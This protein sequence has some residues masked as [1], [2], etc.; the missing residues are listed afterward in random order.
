[1]GRNLK[2]MAVIETGQKSE[3]GR[4]KLCGCGQDLTGFQNLSGLGI[5]KD[6]ACLKSAGTSAEVSSPPGRCRQAEGEK[7]EWII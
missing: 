4:P 6:A 7:K 2:G 3:D 1:M 5:A